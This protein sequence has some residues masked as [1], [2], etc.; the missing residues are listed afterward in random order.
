MIRSFKKW[1]MNDD[2]VVAIEAGLLMPLMLIILMGMFDTGSA[3]LTNQKVINSSQTVSDLLGRYDVI[4]DDVLNE[5]VE[6]GKLM[7]TPYDLSGYGVDVVGIQFDG[8]STNPVEIWRDT[9]N[10]PAN[11][12]IVT[13]AA[14]LGS[15]EEGVIG[16][17]V[18]YTF[19]P[20]FSGGFIGDIN[21]EEVS[22]VRG[23][24]GLFVTR[25]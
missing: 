20:L 24:S 21:F 6:A 17:T 25:E 8:G 11:G 2:A 19:H 10:M 14:G 13:N 23:R 9:I 12:D 4:T 18:N 16:V 15:D 5:C 3:I 7:M 1:L 22:Y